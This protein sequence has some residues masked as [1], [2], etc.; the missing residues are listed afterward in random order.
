MWENKIAVYLIKN[1][2]Y[3][4]IC[5]A[6]QKVRLFFYNS[7]LRSLDEKIRKL[8]IEDNISLIQELKKIKMICATIDEI[9]NVLNRKQYYKLEKH[10]ENDFNDIFKALKLEKL[11]KRK[12]LSI[13]DEEAKEGFNYTLYKLDDISNA[14]AKR[15]S[16]TII[17]NENYTN[18]Q[19]K[20]CILFVTNRIKGEKYYRNNN[21]KK[22]H[23]NKAADVVWL[24]IARDLFDIQTTNWVCRTS[25]IS[26]DLNEVFKPLHLNGNDNIED[27]Q[28]E[29][30]ESYE[31]L[32]KFYRKN[33][34]TKG[35]ILEATDKILSEMKE[36]GEKAINI[37]KQYKKS[38]IT[39]EE[40]INFMQ[41]IEDKVRSLYIASTEIPLP[42]EDLRSYISPC[43]ELF[44]V[45]DNMFLYYSKKGVNT[46]DSKS[47]DWQMSN[48]I[49]EFNKLVHVVKYERDRVN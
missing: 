12:E 11:P 3:T 14:G 4:A 19:I 1:Q 49:E 18:E 29:W 7:G 26:S 32:K 20:S 5:H 41:N 37:F 31:G 24:F 30:N 15:Y 2:R 45:I 8:N 40:F 16:A 35:E 33:Q 10:I 39:E 42:T 21:V 17:L 46:W 44:S 28:I 27:I 23:M 48:S 25:W 34:G 43:H 38:I 9:L 36:Y 22:Q 6:H 13:E 47:R